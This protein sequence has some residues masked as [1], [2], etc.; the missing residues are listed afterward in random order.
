MTDQN[1]G[2]SNADADGSGN[3]GVLRF[4]NIPKSNLAAETA[5]WLAEHGLPVFPIRRGT[6]RPHTEHGVHDAT[7]DAA[8]IAAWSTRWPDANWAVT[9]VLVVDVDVRDDGF[10]SLQE[11]GGLSSSWSVRTGSGGRHLYFALP[12]DV[13]NRGNWLRGVDVKASGGY[14]V[15]PGSI[16]ESGGRYDW[17]AGHAPTE[18]LPSAPQNLLDSIVKSSAAGSTD[19]DFEKVLAGV[20]EGQRDEWLFRAAC[21]LRSKLNDDRGLVEAAV[22]ELAARCNPPFPPDEARTKVRQAFEQD[23][24][25]PAALVEWARNAGSIGTTTTLDLMRSRLLT[26]DDLD[27]LPDPEWLVDGVLPKSALAV[28]Y[29]APGLGKT[30]LGLDWA[31]SVGVGLKWHEREVAPGNVLYVYAEGVHG[32]KQRR[33]AWVQHTGVAGPFDVRFYPRAVPLLDNDHAAALAALS[34]E[35]GSTMVVIDTLARATAGGEENSA[36]DMGRAIAAADAIR[37]ASGATVLLVH[38]TMKDGL[39][40]RGSSA[41]EGAADS[42]LHLTRAQTGGLEL[43]CAKQKDAEPFDPLPLTL[44]PVADSAVLTAGPSLTGFLDQATDGQ[45]LAVLARHAETWLAASDVATEAGLNKRTVHRRL[46]FMA[47]AHAVDRRQFGQTYKYKPK[48][49]P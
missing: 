18:P 44:E 24:D 4:D 1:L 20:A 7:T 19:F 27:S 5:R 39:N 46:T 21:S 41:I 33:T 30:F 2:S 42:M 15:V 47:E 40:Y 22:L 28:L 11:W 13:R 36:K 34:A 31:L 43:K 25:V 16:H 49:T 8:T 37:D 45:I 17:E 6:K 3:A 14:V 23:H 12:D 10:G 35:L 29:G 38:H 9:G 48:W 32:L 26:T